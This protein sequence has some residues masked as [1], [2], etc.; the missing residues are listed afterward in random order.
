MR[1]PRRLTTNYSVGLADVVPLSA[2]L[3][4]PP[5]VLEVRVG[6]HAAS[7][8]LSADTTRR[9]R[10]DLESDG[11]LRVGPAPDGPIY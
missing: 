1:P 10:V 11:T 7:L 3:S 2:P 4:H 9:L 5:V 8:P 6:S